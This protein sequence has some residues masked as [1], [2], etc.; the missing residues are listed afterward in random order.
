MKTLFLTRDQA[1]ALAAHLA[2]YTDKCDS[3]GNLFFRAF[4]ISFGDL[5]S[6]NISTETNIEVSPIA[7]FNVINGEPL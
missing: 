3:N 7:N 1:N 6:V 5:M 4:K 2:E